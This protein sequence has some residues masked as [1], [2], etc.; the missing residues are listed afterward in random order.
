MKIRALRNYILFQFLDRVNTIGQF[1]EQKSD[2]GI[3]ILSDHDKSAKISRWAKIVSL[4]PQCSDILREDNCE[5]LIENLRWTAGVKLE[6]EFIWQTDETQLLGY[7]YPEN[8][9]QVAG[10]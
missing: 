9:D 2:G 1:E 5:I 3:L 6:G 10:A 4:G 7:R 8:M